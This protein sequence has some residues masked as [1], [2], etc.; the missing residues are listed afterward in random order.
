MAGSIRKASRARKSSKTSKTSKK[1]SSRKSSSR[2][3]PTAWVKYVKKYQR[4]HKIE[5]YGLAM[6]QA[7]PSWNARKK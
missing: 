3:K 2:R 7:A 4:D 5:S 6:Q 1:K